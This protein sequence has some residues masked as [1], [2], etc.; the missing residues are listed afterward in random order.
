M[1]V[2]VKAI[3]VLIAVTTV[4]VT[5]MAIVKTRSETFAGK[6][7]ENLPEYGKSDVLLTFGKIM[8]LNTLSANM[9]L[10]PRTM[11][12]TELIMAALMAPSP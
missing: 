9:E 6:M 1:L 5:R 3:P 11:E 7:L 8:A 2:N 10:T 12:S 4:I